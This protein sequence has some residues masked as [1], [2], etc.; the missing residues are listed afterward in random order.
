VATDP[1]TSNIQFLEDA[2]GH[3]IATFMTPQDDLPFWMLS[4]TV[5]IQVQPAN[6]VAAKR[7]AAANGWK[8]RMVQNLIAQEAVTER[9]S[10]LAETII[11][12]LPA[13]D[14]GDTFASKTY[15]ADE[16]THSLVVS[17]SPSF[18]FVPLNFSSPGDGD[19]LMNISR[20]LTFIV[21]LYGESPDST[22]RV[23]LKWV[24]WR[25]RYSV[26]FTPTATPT[27]NDWVFAFDDG[28]TTIVAQGDGPGIG[29][30]FQPLIDD[31][32][33]IIT[34]PKE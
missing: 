1:Q 13:L 26:A 24:K 25:V 4:A 32:S 9:F 18:Q 5:K 6:A 29:A 33:E 10:T 8:I 28:A 3:P 34:V 2:A 27:G 30:V 15:T 21:Y 12:Q 16:Q 23:W 17:D 14:D 19:T 31:V 11:R 7:D 20:D 22:Q